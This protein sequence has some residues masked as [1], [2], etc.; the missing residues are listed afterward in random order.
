[1]GVGVGVGVEVEVGL[2]TTGALLPA[3][4]TTGNVLFPV[5][6]EHKSRILLHL[7]LF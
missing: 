4:G 6:P 5:E 3:G 2:R 7:N 1:M